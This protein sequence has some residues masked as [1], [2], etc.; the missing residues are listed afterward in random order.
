[1]AYGAER[2]GGLPDIGQPERQL[3]TVSRLEN[4]C[5]PGCGSPR[6]IPVG[7]KISIIIPQ[8]NKLINSIVAGID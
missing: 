5:F 6:K 1:M 3:G 4:P 7:R 8:I 2:D